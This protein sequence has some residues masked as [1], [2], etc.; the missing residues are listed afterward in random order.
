MMIVQEIATR[1]D[2]ER[3]YH[4]AWPGSMRKYLPRA[5]P[6]KGESKTLADSA[7]AITATH[8]GWLV[9]MT[10]PAFRLGLR[11]LGRFQKTHPAPCFWPDWQ[12][13]YSQFATMA[14][15]N[16]AKRL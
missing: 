11:R 12:V 1:Q 7:G 14:L 5:P 6:S 4:H 8:C 2:P 9:R 16:W 13:V 10:W 3:A 15:A